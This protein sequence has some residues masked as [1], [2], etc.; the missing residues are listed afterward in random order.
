MALR[1]IEVYVP[2]GQGWDVSRVLADAPILEIWRRDGNAET[3][4]TRLLVDEVHT[5][6]VLNRLEERFE[7]TEGFRAVILPVEA[8]IPKIEPPEETEAQEKAAEQ[9]TARISVQELYTDVRDMTKLTP[10]YLLLVGL[11]AVVAAIGLLQD[12]VAVIIGSMVIAPLLGPSMAFALSITLADLRLAWEATKAQAAGVALAL[13]VSVGMGWIFSVDPSIPSIELRTQPALWDV[14]LGLAV[15]A[16]GVLSVTTGVSTA[17]VGVM[18]AVALVP[19]LVATGL[20]AGAGLWAP[21]LGAAVLLAVYVI[22]INLSGVAVF[23]M[24]GVRP[25]RYWE[26][27][28]ARWATWITGAL[29]IAMLALLTG[30]VLAYR[31]GLLTP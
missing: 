4:L 30:A 18:V 6:A 25:R 29:W 24:Q 23:A 5:E 9:A 3:T 19:P 16:A 22:S 13:A 8:T 7:D 12:N 31:R 21:A 10:V 27:N 28:K 14:A 26:A 17:L 1:V 11:A 2:A 15:G 20:L